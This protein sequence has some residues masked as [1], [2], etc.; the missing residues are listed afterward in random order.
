MLL[1]HTCHL[2]CEVY[3][4]VGCV[5]VCISK[6][7]ASI[8]ACKIVAVL[9]IFAMWQPYLF[10]DIKYVFSD[11]G[12]DVCTHACICTH[13]HAYMQ[14]LRLM[15]VWLHTYLRYT[16]IYVCMHTYM[17]IYIHIYAC[18]DTY[19]STCLKNMYACTHKYMY[20]YIHIPTV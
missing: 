6:N 15:Y 19:I 11:T 3:N 13:T 1:A 18:L 10:S 20:A 14:T 7:V 8:W 9:L 17:S 5:L 2:T 16:F 12:V 4:A